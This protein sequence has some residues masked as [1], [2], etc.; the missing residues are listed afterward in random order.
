MNKHCY[1][2]V[3]NKA[4]GRLVVAS[5]AAA[6]DRHDGSTTPRRRAGAPA[7]PRRFELGNLKPLTWSTLLALGLV[8]LPSQAQIAPDRSAPSSQRPHVLESANGTPQVN[9]TTPNSKGVSRNA[10]R[11]F[12][13]DGRGAILNNARSATQT[14]IGGWVQGNPNLSAGE[15][16]VIVNEVNSSNPSRLHGAVEI[17]G[18][19]AE[20]VIANPAGIDVD[21]AGFINAQGVTLTTGQPQFRN[22]ALDGYRVEGGTV[23]IHGDGL[24]TGDADYAAILARA[25]E[26]QAGV[27]AEEL[28]VVAGANRISADLRTIEAIEGDGDTPGVAIDV[29]HLGGMYAGKIR[30]VANERGVGVNN[31]GRVVASQQLTVTADGRLEN[32]GE[33]S[34]GGELRLAG[35]SG[36]DNQGEIQAGGNAAI[37]GQ[38]VDNQGAIRAG[39]DL[40]VTG[41]DAL[42]NRTGATLIA[43]GDARLTA[44]GSVGT[45]LS[46]QDATLAAGIRD[47]DP[48]AQGDLQLTATQ[49][50][51]ANGLNL[52]AGGFYA[53]ADT[54]SLEASRT[55]ARE[56]ALTARNGDIDVS[57]AEVMAE[58]RLAAN[59][60]ATLRTDAATV[61]AGQLDIAA[62]D[63][64]NRGGELSQSG[65][66]ALLLELETLDNRDGRLASSG[67]MALHADTLDN[68]NGE[69]LSGGILSVDA[70]ELDN[71][72]GQLLAQRSLDLQAAS[73][74]NA[75][76]TL[77]A[78]EE[79]LTVATTGVIDNRDGS[80]EAGDRLTLNGQGLDN[81]GGQLQSLGDMTLD[82]N[83]ALHNQ[84]GLV[85]SGAALTVNAN[86][87]VNSATQGADQGVEGQ[88]VDITAN[89]VI[90]HQ[91]A[92]RAN[93]RLELD[94][95]SRVDN[96]NGL[97]SSLDT[98]AL[99]TDELD[100]Q[101]G[102][103][104]ANQQ[105]DLT[106]A[107][108]IGDGRVLSLGDLA[109]QLASDFTL[110]QSA[111]LKAAGD[112]QFTTTGTLTNRGKLQAG[113]TL[114][115]D[116]GAIDNTAGGELS[117]TTT[118]LSAGQLTNRGLID[119]VTTRIDATTQNNLGTGRIYGDLLG[120]QATTLTNDVENGRAAV[121]AA[122][123]RLDIGAR[124]LTNREQALL[125]S[126]GDMAIGGS[127][128]ANDRAT[129]QAT[130][131]DNN[132][133]TIEALGD[134]SISAASLRNTNEHF[135]T[136]LELSGGGPK[137]VTYLQPSG[138]TDKAP[139]IE[140]TEG[141]FWSQQTNSYFPVYTHDFTEQ[142][143]WSWYEYDLEI[144]E[145]N[146]VVTNSLPAVIMAGRGLDIN[147][148]VLNNDKSQIVAGGRV[149]ANLDTVENIEA[150]GKR[151]IY[152]VGRVRNSWTK[153]N[154]EGH[155]GNPGTTRLWSDWED[156]NNSLSTTT[157]DLKVGEFGGNR[158]V[159]SSG[160]QIGA[161]QSTTVSGSASGA[162][163]LETGRGIV[164][165]P[166]IDSGG[167][168]PGEVIRTLM[169]N[170]RLP[171]NSLFRVRPNP[172]ATYLVETDPRF[173]DRRQWMSSDYL[174]DHLSPDP[175][176]THKRLGDGF[177]E[178]RLIR[179]Q[180]TELT[181]Q[182]FLEG[183][184]DDQAQ[185]AALMN[186]A[187]T[188]AQEHGLRPGV[189][190]SAEQMAQLTSDIVWLV[191]QKV[192]L[193]D[194]S[195]A[196]VLVPQVYTRLR[197][198]DL[199]GDGTLIAGDSLQLDVA[200]DL[201]NSGTLAGRE[202][203]EISADNLTNLEGRIRGNRVDLET[204]RDLTNLGGDITASESLSLQAGRD[205]NL[206]STAERLAGLYV[207]DADGQL[208][209]GAGRDLTI[210]GA[211]VDSAGS[212]Q[213]TA[214]RDLDIASTLDTQSTGYGR[215]TL[216]RADLDRQATL[217]AGQD[218]TLNAGRDLGLTAVDVSAGGDGLITAGRDLSLETLTTGN[219]LSG[220]RR[221]QYSRQQEVST[222]LAFGNDL[223]LLAG[224]DLYARAA[225][226]SAASD[227]GVIAGRDIE[228]EAGQSSRHEERRNYR[229]HTIDS[230]S[231]V[232]GS[233]FSAGDNLALSAGN[234][235]RLTASRLQAGDE[236]SLLAGRDVEL[237]TAQEQDYSLYKEKSSGGLFGSSRTRRDEVSKTRSIGSEVTTGGDLLVASG[238]DHTYQAARLESGGDIELRSGGAIRFETASDVHTESHER[239]SSSF[240]WQSSS[241]EGLTRETLRQSELVAQGELIIQAA[242]GLQI[243]V[244]QIDRRSVSRTIDAMV[245][246]N[247]D[248]AWLQ[249]MEQRG[250]VDWRRVKA[251]HDSWD[252]EQSGLG[253]G[254][255][256]AITIVASAM[257]QHYIGPL[258]GSAGGVAAGSLAGTGAISL[259]N[260][261][262]D[263]GA[264]L[265]DT[266]SSDSLRNA[267]TAALT[268]GVTEGIDS[269]WGGFT[270]TTT[271]ATSGLDLGS[272]G[273]IARFAGNR[274][275]Q[276]LANAGLQTAINGGSFE[277]NLDAALQGAVHHVVSG[278]LFNAVG[279]FSHNRFANGSPEKIALHALA[280]GLSAEAMGGDF[281][282]GAMAAGANE[283]LMEYLDSRLGS[284]PET[285]THLLTTASQLVGIV[286]AELVNGDV[287]Q[288]AEIAAQATR[289][290][291]LAHPEAKRLQEL[292]RLL[293]DENL[294]AAQRQALE[295]ERLAIQ[296]LSQS[297]DLALEEACGQGGSAQACSYERS[298]LRV[299]MSSWQ[300]VTM[301]RE[302]RDTVFAE[303]LHT[304]RQYGQHQQQ[305]MERIGAEALSEMVVDSVN[306]PIIM[307]QLVG[308]ALLGDAESQALL[309]EMGQEIQAF[310][311]NPLN[312]ITES[313]REQLAQADALEL[314]G[315]Q[316]E[317]DR[318]RMRVALENQSM[319]MGAGGLVASL[320]RL[321]R[322]VVTSRSGMAGATVPSVEAV[323]SP[324]RVGNLQGGPLEN[325]TQ[326]SGRFKLESGPPNGTVFRA[327]NQGNITS[328]ATYD[329]NGQ[330]LKRVDVTGAAHN[331]IQ[332][333]HVLEYGRNTLPD[334]SVRVQSP[335]TN[336][337]PVTPDEVP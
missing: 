78:V 193:E 177:Y 203:V 120:I 8:A 310:A 236:A 33:L 303:Y 112:L 126:A 3:F 23:R 309:R 317:A 173:T 208:L 270:N 183:Y 291:Y 174:L 251:I 35:R 47:G 106:A 1:R 129:G 167:A 172:T 161:L 139:L 209:A 276:G 48:T 140:F 6:T 241:G 157:T 277:R 231:R 271:N 211:A 213:L 124:R 11:Q 319:L 113:D 127:L 34:S 212:L 133:A 285:R 210:R 166:G 329:A 296:T 25:A 335:R 103:L 135:E 322:N 58:Q 105:L 337:R 326:V 230:Q 16:R 272:L 279:D 134:L 49:G 67:D 316:D 82:L 109:L 245:A 64:S 148:G 42:T 227:L 98:L 87:V 324:R 194:G 27:W 197:E 301:G 333:P 62:R 88:S 52:A 269:V 154:Y 156:Y 287:Y 10:Y 144:T 327:D 204:R 247:P 21:G 108:L 332:T 336:P 50:I 118:R 7:S 328:Y 77:G 168:Q 152:E 312:Y 71:A 104:I 330:I 150:E 53:E 267:A 79:D 222:N 283:A 265:S 38:V 308:Q 323:P 184:A 188:F 190:L 72:Q 221:F 123:E 65:D 202:L 295:D 107:R 22:G 292:N 89:D 263:L 240:A 51:E 68:A 293:E 297:R 85:R 180:V 170:V 238:Q 334:G 158:N 215:A 13:V 121:I 321:A 266:F 299:A 117:A 83:Q 151:I 102:T 305:R 95:A 122:R 216:S 306:A 185:Y 153:T 19:R 141:R 14:Q 243:D 137:Q 176:A 234:D 132:S 246:A 320:P 253:S 233:E 61:Q 189:A 250:D 218:L 55:Q 182:R 244:E 252:Y 264:A 232:Q 290:N 217:T 91:G 298:L 258:L 278:V 286:A 239:S 224:Q 242:E 165:I 15:A 90:N 315:Q 147:G 136:R 76:G 63:L 314:A 220:N 178:Q 110:N 36:I 275:T 280:G 44:T 5:E 248:L 66:T 142:E 59:T 92:M 268:A 259:V 289:Y 307:G 186:N 57:A 300:D 73:L 60:A 313:N 311:D 125:F 274:A 175:A 273:D 164:E 171:S 145:Y 84:G 282:T 75:D 219:V 223:T 12:D 39:A 29:A 325:A 198:G 302:D 43:G 30:L 24:N 143:I 81:T 4:K 80:L 196:K 2:L 195:T 201:F 130:R 200:G 261:R 28:E 93:Q 249:E 18:R 70:G 9:I 155:D 187:V 169:P 96:R 262:G 40:D 54:V 116:A 41:R 45:I 255:A 86:R 294:T 192:T 214:G 119:G 46:E 226:V 179:E 37:S 160:T 199:K 288:G 256:L 331:G 20:V 284:D 254:V 206:A 318:L 100:N 26:I 99:E 235:L 229:K 260:N 228:I 94:A 181:G 115:L 207:T 74:N 162:G 304:A 32:R 31:A 69:I 146:S 56:I 225:D 114:D 191:E 101:G 159:S 97:L 111:E 138:W 257:G 163:D 17:A 205:L 128:D 149:L 131:V 237:L 281:R